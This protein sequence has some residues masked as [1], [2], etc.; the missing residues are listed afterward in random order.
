V[1]GL[2]AQRVGAGPRVVLV[3]GGVL[4][5]A[6]TWGEQLPL[7]ERWELTIVDRAGYGRSSDLNDG[8]DARVDA[9]LLAEL[10]DGGAHLVGQ[11]SGAVAALLAAAQRPEAVRSL[12]LSEPP[13]FQLAPRSAAAQ[14]MQ[15]DL[16]R[17]IE[18]R[19]ADDVTVLRRFVEIVGS[20]AQVGDEP[21]QPLLDG[22]RALRAYRA[23]AIPWTLAL[24]LDAL[25]AAPF[26][27]LVISGDHSPAFEA[28]CDALAEHLDAE[29]A[30]VTGAK[31]T[32][33]HVG[34]AF[35]ERLE[36]FLDAAERT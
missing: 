31:H 18:D 25:A 21:P 27:K 10:L 14:Q 29:R 5:G 4:F 6:L 32:T 3:H 20:N 15:R 28:V 34:A 30:R 19:A 17:M 12:T 9:P 35:N 33:P 2:F 8:E 16:A 11:S 23:E 7:A 26:P 1:G 36:A 13:A 24:P 22:I